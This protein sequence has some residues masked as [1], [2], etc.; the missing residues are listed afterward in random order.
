LIQLQ[1]DDEEDSDDKEDGE[2]ENNKT[3]DE[4]KKA[5]RKPTSFGNEN[6]RLDDGGWTFTMRD[7]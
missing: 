1:D 3:G 5:L 7:G 2:V 4:D 6:Y